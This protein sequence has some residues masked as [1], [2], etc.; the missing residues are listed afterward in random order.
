MEKNGLRELVNE[1]NGNEKRLVPHILTNIKKNGID[2]IKF[3][4]NH[5]LDDYASKHHVLLYNI[6]IWIFIYH[7]PK[8][9]IELLK[10]AKSIDIKKLNNEQQNIVNYIFN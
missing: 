1:L 6:N 2:D 7:N 5:D 8:V 4:R 10:I 9:Y 3:M